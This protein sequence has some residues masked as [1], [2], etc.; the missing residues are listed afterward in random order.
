MA[1]RPEGRPPVGADGRP[2][3]RA[4]GD[5]GG[6][7]PGGRGV[8]GLGGVALARYSPSG[9]S[10]ASKRSIC[11]SSS[12]TLFCTMAQTISSSIVG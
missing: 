12:G 8:E 6:G 3:G 4:S 5:D 7:L 11:S 2:S 9:N 1:L 10:A